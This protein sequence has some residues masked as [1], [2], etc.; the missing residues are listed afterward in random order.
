[1]LA[2]EFKGTLSTIILVL[3]HIH[4]VVS[5]GTAKHPI[6]FVAPIAES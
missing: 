6:G 2:A 3:M 5:T 4:F 1:M